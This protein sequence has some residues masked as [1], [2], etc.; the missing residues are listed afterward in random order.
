LLRAEKNQARQHYSHVGY[1]EHR[2]PHWDVIGQPMFITF[3]LHE[4][5]PRRRVFL[6]AHVQ[7]GG[8][9]VAMDRLLDQ[10]ATGPKYLG[11]PEIA[12]MVVCSLK[13]GAAELD[14]YAMHSFV[15]MPNH[16][17]MLVTPNVPSPRWLGPLK[18]FT[19]HEANRMLNRCGSFWQTESYDHL[20]RNRDEF[21]RIRRYIENNPVKAGLRASPEEFRWS[22]VKPA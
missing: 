15:I 1:S 17:H 19:A 7:A 2:L 11:I 14:R 8:A 12:A 16:V 20:V 9:F 21:E 22:S 4:S 10:A 18:G 3:R 5:L 13:H 6:P